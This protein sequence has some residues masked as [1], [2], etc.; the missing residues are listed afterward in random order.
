MTHGKEIFKENFF[1]CVGVTNEL[2]VQHVMT[3][4]LRIVTVANIRKKKSALGKQVV[5]TQRRRSQLVVVKS[6]S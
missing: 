1:W 6:S 5:A 2:V 4:Y 3:Y